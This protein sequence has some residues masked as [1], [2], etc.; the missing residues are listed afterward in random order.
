MA[1]YIEFNVS[2]NGSHFFATSA[3]SCHS[4]DVTKAHQLWEVLH[5]KFPPCE[6]YEITA[7]KVEEIGRRWE[8]N[9]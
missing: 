9:L 7:T 8:P 6:G 3:R 5:T 2:K 1:S 4:T